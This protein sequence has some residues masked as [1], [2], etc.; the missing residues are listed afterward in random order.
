MAKDIDSLDALLKYH[1]TMGSPERALSNNL[2]GIDNTKVVSAK[3]LNQ[4]RYGYTFFS[5]PILNLGLTNLRRDR[6][7]L[8]LSN[9]VKASAESYVRCMLDPRLQ[10]DSN[11]SGAD[12]PLVD[13]NNIWIPILQNN[14]VNVSGWPDPV[15]P[16]FSSK[17]GA[18][19]EK[20]V[21]VDGIK[22]INGDFDL[23]LTF[24]NTEDQILPKLLRYWS[25]YATL[26]FENTMIPYHDM[27]VENEMDYNCA[28][29]R[30]VMDKDNKR[31][32]HI[33]KAISIIPLNDPMGK[34]FDFSRETPYSDQTKQLSYRF[35]CV[36]PEYD[37]DILVKEFNETSCDLNPDLERI[38]NG[39]I[40]TTMELVPDNISHLLR[41]RVYPL[42]NEDTYELEWYAFSHAIKYFTD[43]I[44]E[45]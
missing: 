10:L 4:N 37:E 24:E 23:D 29:Y 40:S 17:E 14:L 19:K 34:L 1:T 22:E 44:E 11:L 21:Q 15:T 38:Y 13:K 36:F 43:K 41:N 31:V 33:A 8:Q 32:N 2:Y 25:D 3:M 27:W 20:Y 5:R 12:C 18:R 39:G 7:F 42:I 35:K 28:I 45:E 26:V 16:T 9:R 30:L 6:R